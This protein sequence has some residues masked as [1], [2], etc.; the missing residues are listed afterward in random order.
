MTYDDN[1][2]ANCTLPANKN[3]RA[4][5]NQDG[6]RDSSQREGELDILSAGHN[7][8]ELHRKPK[9]EE[10]VKLEQCNV[11]LKPSQRLLCYPWRSRRT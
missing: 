7:D 1:N 3:R 11:D 6:H 2:H 5:Q 10:K 4:Y 8:H 9:E